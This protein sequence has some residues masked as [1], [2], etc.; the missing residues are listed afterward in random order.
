[1]SN[2]SA[3]E[4]CAVAASRLH[5]TVHPRGLVLDEID[6]EERVGGDPL[7]ADLFLGVDQNG[8]VE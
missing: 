2:T 5:Q 7:E 1:V 8:A 4:H 6:V 3:S